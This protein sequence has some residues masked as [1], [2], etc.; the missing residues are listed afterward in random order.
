MSENKEE[1]FDQIE[2]TTEDKNLETQ[3]DKLN[4]K[5]ES[6]IQEIDS[7]TDACQITKEKDEKDQQMV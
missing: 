5:K 1:I 4:K 3:Y 7:L 6:L 2:Q